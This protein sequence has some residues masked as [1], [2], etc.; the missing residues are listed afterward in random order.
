MFKE[1]YDSF[2][3]HPGL[4]SL[5]IAGCIFYMARQ[6]SQ[7]DSLAVTVGLGLSA[8]SLLDAWLTSNQAARVL[9]EAMRSGISFLFV[10]LGDAR[11][12]AMIALLH[13]RKQSG[14]SKGWLILPFLCAL[15]VPLLSQG[16]I[17]L[18]GPADIRF[19]YLIYEILF[20]FWPLTFLYLFD[21]RRI[22]LFVFLYYGLWALADALILAGLDAGFLLRIVPNLLYY[23]GLPCI[24]FREL[25][26]S[27]DAQSKA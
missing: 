9:P 11:Y 15:L 4:L 14:Y 25:N 17:F 7:A 22:H 5:A 13:L 10:Y 3:Q 12:F 6:R 27:S 16:L 21:F 19:L 18:A 24:A 26:R 20:L 23:A 8:L 2:Y 1:F